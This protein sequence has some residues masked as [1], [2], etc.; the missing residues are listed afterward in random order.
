MIIN[1]GRFIERSARKFVKHVEFNDLG[2]QTGEIKRHLVE[3]IETE[4]SS[5][6]KNNLYDY[7]PIRELR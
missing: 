1:V 2:R 5:N 7:W 6:V 4:L 3:Y